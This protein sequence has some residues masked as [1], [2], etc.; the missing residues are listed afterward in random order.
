MVTL[1]EKQLTGGMI[2]LALILSYTVIVTNWEQTY[3]CSSEDSV[4]ECWRLSES[5][6]SCYYD[7]L[8]PTKRDLCVGGKW[9]P[10]TEY[11]EKPEKLKQFNVTANNKNWV[12]QIK[13]EVVS[14]YTKCY[15][16]IYEGY[17]GELV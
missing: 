15:S 2:S 5:E 16:D 6:R 10:I 3:Y 7:K 14:S 12:C 13:G 9:K 17:L 1:R 11:I 4:K 8:N